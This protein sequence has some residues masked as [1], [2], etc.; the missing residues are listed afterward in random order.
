MLQRTEGIVLKTTPF[1]E[2][3]LIVTYITSDY[4]ILKAFAKS[5]R[6]IK[7]RFGSSLEPLTCAKI[8]FW[9]KEDA[10]LPRLTQSDIIH[11]FDCIRG[12]LRSF[13][14]ASEILE[15]TLAFLPERDAHINVYSLLL[16]TLATMEKGSG[17]DL[18]LLC[19]KVK[20]LQLVGYLPRLSDCGRCGR[21]GDSF[22]LSHG[23]VLCRE[24]SLEYESPRRL[25]GGA[26]ALCNNLVG[27][28]FSKLSRLRPSEMLVNELSSVI[29][30]HVRYVTERD[31]KT[32]AFKAS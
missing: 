14:K 8:A 1:G 5:P 27:W 7:S 11:P 23:A 25:S 22:F 2:A 6:K 31:L 26:A 16:D 21:E 12:E 4:G 29:D 10:A 3:D 13:L 19:Y 24:C 9:G 17:T 20:L 30:D 32:R 15:L 28:E 18:L